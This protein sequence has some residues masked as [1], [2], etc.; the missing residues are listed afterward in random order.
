MVGILARM[1]VYSLFVSQ[2]HDRLDSNGA[3]GW[4]QAW[5]TP[6]R[7]TTDVATRSVAGSCGDVFH[8]WF[9]RSWLVAMSW[10]AAPGLTSPGIARTSRQLGCGRLIHLDTLK[11]P[12]LQIGVSPSARGY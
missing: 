12:A 3:A 11:S 4:D 1:R 2:C 10:Q 9:T 8:S 7:K 5:H 6:M